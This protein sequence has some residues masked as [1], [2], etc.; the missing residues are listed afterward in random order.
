VH[1]PRPGQDFQQLTEGA[2]MW[3][4]HGVSHGRSSLGY[5]T[6]PTLQKQAVIYSNQ[7]ARQII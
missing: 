3:F 4:F 2:I 6:V 7:E 5:F 1:G